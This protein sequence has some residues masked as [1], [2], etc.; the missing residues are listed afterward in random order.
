MWEEGQFQEGKKIWD[1][2]IVSMYTVFSIEVST[3]KK[4]KGLVWLFPKD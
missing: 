4:S 1:Q 3:L 2:D